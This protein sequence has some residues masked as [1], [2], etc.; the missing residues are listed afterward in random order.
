MAKKTIAQINK[1]IR[2]LKE[3]FLEHSP[4]ENALA[5][6]KYGALIIETGKRRGEIRTFSE[7]K[8]LYTSGRSQYQ[9]SGKSY[10]K[11]LEKFRAE[12]S[13][14]SVDTRSAIERENMIEIMKA[15][16]QEVIYGIVKQK[17]DEYYKEHR[18]RPSD[19]TIWAYKMNA[20]KNYKKFFTLSTA[21][22]LHIFRQAEKKQDKK[23]YQKDGESD[24]TWYELLGIALREY[25]G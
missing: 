14:L 2:E 18:E 11:S 4:T 24:G 12:F 6:Q 21:E 25:L 17:I 13:D 23:L 9:Y 16:E 1:E 15:D 7:V 3:S 19:K 10:V 5:R 8:K 22:M 20:K